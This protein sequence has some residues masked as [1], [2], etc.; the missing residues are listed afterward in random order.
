MPIYEY[1][2]EN[3]GHHFERFQSVQDA[4]LRQCPQCSGRVH[5]VF[6]PVGIIFK[7]S[8]WYITDSRTSTSSTSED[9][10]ASKPDTTSKT[11]ATT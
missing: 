3:C 1:E 8:G 6:H 2:C 9:K 11:E 5:K 4:P 10:T 7:G